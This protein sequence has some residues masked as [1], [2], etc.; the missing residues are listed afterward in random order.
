MMREH[1]YFV[2]IYLR[3]SRDDEDIDGSTK[4]ESNSI[5]SQRELIRSYVR[6]H[7]DME[8][9]DIYVDDGYSGAN[10]VEVR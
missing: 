5:S 6:E 8:L 4:A 2:A 1:I 3:L 9:F 7:D 10:F